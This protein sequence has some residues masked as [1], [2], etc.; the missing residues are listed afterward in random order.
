MYT[1]LNNAVCFFDGKLD[2]RDV[3]IKDGKLF[4]EASLF[5]PTKDEGFSVI[6][7]CIV[8]PGFLDVHVHL[9]E[10]GFS[11]KEKIFTGTRAAAKGGYTAVCSMPNLNPVPDSA[12]TLKQQTDIIKRDACISVIPYGAITKGEK[13]EELADMEGMAPT[14]AAFSDD[15][16]GVQDDEMMRSAMLK[17]KSLGKIIAAHCEDN[18][19]LYGGYINDCD[20]AKKNGHAGICNKSEWK[21]IERDIELVRETGCDYHVCHISTKES[22]EL[23]LRAKAEGLSVTCETAPHYLILDD[24][25]LEEDARFKMNP[26]LRS[27]EDKR[28]LIE[29]VLDGT[30]DMIATDHAPHS[31]E[32]KSRGLKSSPMGITGIETAFPILYTK[33]IEPGI[34]P[35]ERILEMMVTAP[36]KRFGIKE[37][38]DTF[39]VIKTGCKDRIDAKDFV[40][41]GHSTPFD[42]E[43]VNAQCIMTVYKGRTVWQTNTTER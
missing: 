43:E 28:A 29:G 2:S 16:R 7:N 19:L 24:T 13:G 21:Q 35:L 6:E 14:V 5:V 36:R 41:M 40:S 37:T 31:D 18:S 17:A 22:V 4:N 1:L 12:E 15:G 20:Y 3:Y 10:P 34:I 30:I 27:P 39:S 11:Y 26:P 9:R 32:E 8:T 38:P 25:Y 42:G 33:L 23:I